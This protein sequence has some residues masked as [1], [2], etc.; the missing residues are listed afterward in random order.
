MTTGATYSCAMT[1]ARDISY[2]TSVGGGRLELLVVSGVWDSTE[3]VR[4][5]LPVSVVDVGWL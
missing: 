3:S 1:S 4:Q 2:K 5:P